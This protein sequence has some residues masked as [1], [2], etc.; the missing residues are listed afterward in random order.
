MRWTKIKVVMN[1]ADPCVNAVITDDIRVRH[2][3]GGAGLSA[4]FAA[5]VRPLC[6]SA[7]R[8]HSRLSTLGRK[9]YGRELV[10]M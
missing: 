5:I 7:G 6:L 3:K 8:L 10:S 2:A 9:W 4:G 1:G